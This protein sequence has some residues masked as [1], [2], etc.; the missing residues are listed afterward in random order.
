MENEISTVVFEEITATQRLDKKKYFQCSMY[1]LRR[2]FGI[3][4]IILLTVL[5]ALSVW[6]H[7]MYDI[8]IVLIFFGIS[9]GL[10]FIALGLFLITSVWGYKHD[11][12]STGVTYHKLEFL[13]DKL[14]AF[15]LDKGGEAYFSEEHSYA[16]IEKVAIKHMKIY[17]YAGVAVFYYIYRESVGDFDGLCEFLR[18]HLTE[19]KFKIKKTIRKFP[20]RDKI[21]LG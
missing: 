18:Q 11:F 6:L 17:I 7:I 20:K 16:K 2:F 5:F 4:E 3:R 10:V 14:I 15:S 19:D 1:Y 9:T 13:E 21:K 12:Q 8:F